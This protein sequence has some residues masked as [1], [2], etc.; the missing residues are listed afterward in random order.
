MPHFYLRVVPSGETKVIISVS[1]KV[2]RKAVARNL[3]KRR[4][5]PLLRKILPSLKPAT[6]MFIAVG[7][8]DKIRGKELEAE[9]N[10]LVVSRTR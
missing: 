4:V 5:R 2:A 6:Y 3:I 7:D 8:A 1:K 10:S 9:I